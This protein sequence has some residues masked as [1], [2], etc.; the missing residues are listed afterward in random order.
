[1]GRI[2]LVGVSQVKNKFIMALYNDGKTRFDDEFIDQFDKFTQDYLRIKRYKLVDDVKSEYCTLENWLYNQH[3]D[4]IE[5]EL[6]WFFLGRKN[7]RVE[8]LVR[9]TVFSHLDCNVLIKKLEEIEGEMQ[10]ENN[11][12]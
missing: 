2:G 9:D 8:T 7:T 4:E 10:K 1:M 3:S 6:F 11:W 12:D 5:N